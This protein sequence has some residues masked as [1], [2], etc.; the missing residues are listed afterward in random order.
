MNDGVGITS[1]TQLDEQTMAWTGA[2]D[3][4]R[5]L[6]SRTRCTFCSNAGTP[7]KLATFRHASEWALPIKA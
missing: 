2:I 3:W 4:L 5:D 7:K 1:H 6:P